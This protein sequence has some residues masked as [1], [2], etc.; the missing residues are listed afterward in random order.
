M[1]II[2]VQQTWSL[3]QL[4]FLVY[5]ILYF[6]AYVGVG[7]IVFVDHSI[8]ESRQDFCSSSERS[9]LEHY[10]KTPYYLITYS[11]SQPNT[12]C[13]STEQSL[14]AQF[15]RLVG[16]SVY[17]FM[18]KRSSEFFSHVVRIILVGK[19]RLQRQQKKQ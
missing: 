10:P 14:A 6:R 19:V 8:V 11:S 9:H 12:I 5:F 7:R 16:K 4:D 3:V 17:A 13:V 2:L 15:V 18:Q 1:S